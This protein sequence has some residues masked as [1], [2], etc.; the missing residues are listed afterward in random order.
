MS[1]TLNE[2]QSLSQ[3]ILVFRTFVKLLFQSVPHG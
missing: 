2:P 1:K 3:Q